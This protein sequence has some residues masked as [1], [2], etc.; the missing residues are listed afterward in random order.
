M[1]QPSQEAIAELENILELSEGLINPEDVVL[2]AAKKT[3]PLHDYFEWQDGEA[4]HQYR[5][6][7]ARKLI[8]VWVVVLPQKPQSPVRMMVSLTSD[9]G[10]LGYRRL[11][12]V[13]E[14][15][16]LRAKLLEESKRDMSYFRRK[17]ALLSELAGVF[18]A[19]D[20]I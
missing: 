8:R 5:L 20:K 14:D 4:A 6:Y 11:T 17:Y 7:Q 13:M 10:G 19:M 15:A 12:D 18:A 3:N 1:K 9:R 16:E 2:R